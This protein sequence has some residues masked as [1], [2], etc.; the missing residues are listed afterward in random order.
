MN[1]AVWIVIILVASVAGWAIGFYLRRTETSRKARISEAKATEL[2][3]ETEAKQ[4]ELLLQA[5]EEAVKIKSEA[6]NEY[7]QRRIEISRLEKKFGQR[8]E[9]LDR[10]VESFENRERTL[11][12]KEREI[13]ASL[14][15]V[16]KFKQEQRQKLEVISGMS[17]ADAKEQLL[18]VVETETR[19]A[20][21]KRMRQ[22]E[23]Q[24]KAEVNERSRIITAEALQRCASEVAT[25]ATV[26]VV[27][28]PN[29]EMK[30]RLIG[31]EGRNIRALE[32]A[33]GVDLIVDDTPE[34]VTLS[35]FDPV[36]REIARVALAKL[37]LDGRINPVRIEEIVEKARKEVDSTI[38]AEGEQLAFRAGVVGLQP[39]IVRTLG[40]LR[41][42]F[43]Y[44]QNML[45]HSLETSQLSAA[46]AT[47][48]GA[49]VTIAKTGGLLH[50]IG[51]AVDQDVEGPHAL[52]GANIL[53]RLGVSSDI[54]NAV[55]EHHGETGTN[56]TYG[57][58]V[59]A[60][61]AISSARPGARQESVEHYLKRIEALENIAESFAGVEKSYAI[62]AGREV[63]ILVKPNQIDDLDSVRLARDIAKKIEGELE[64][65]GQI[66]VTVIRETRSV[67]YAK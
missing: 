2:V 26:S 57:F 16:E 64:Y 14:A 10:K 31:R 50:D 59:S 41:Y 65:P 7:R 19:D 56:S 1:T 61:D 44:G 67:D 33:T 37:I 38:Q 28:L 58:I 11:S 51:K 6:E 48:I 12:Q 13:E 60:A 62:Q 34:A 21:A 29:D 45:S 25:E 39:E 15:Q 4:K 20:L 17:S 35:C 46:L 54:V 18:R 40:R 42:R 32:A 22:V 36:R 53:K 23:E 63:R 9:N 66:K 49:D 52:I 24:L 30:G 55:A 43:S 5:K 8:L 47:E 27:A 3:K